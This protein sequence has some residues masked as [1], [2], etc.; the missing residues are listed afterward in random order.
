MFDL[1]VINSVLQELE[2]ERG[3][4]R[5]RIIEAEG[6]TVNDTDLEQLAEKDAPKVGIEKARL[7]TFYKSSSA[8]A[9]RI[10]SGKVMTFL[11]A[12]AKI[13]EKVTDKFIE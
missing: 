12:H 10:L 4:P 11:K 7:L 8:V 6:I 1:K 13:T 2:E 5:E 9:D 3:I